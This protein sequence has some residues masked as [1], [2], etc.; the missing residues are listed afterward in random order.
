LVPTLLPRFTIAALVV[1][2]ALAST[3]RAATLPAHAEVRVGQC[4]A[5]SAFEQVVAAR[6]HVEF[7]R[8]VA[9]DIDR[10]GD[11]D[12]LATT[13]RSFTVWIN[14]GAGHLTAQRPAPGPSLEQRPWSNTFRGQGERPDPTVNADAPTFA[15]PTPRAHAPPVVASV[16]A[17]RL[18]GSARSFFLL[19]SSAP[20][21]PPLD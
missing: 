4:V 2:V 14:D 5:T 8:V 15:V 9:T 21:A 7:R 13:D 17:A 18:D 16:R 20:R 3:G 19:A 12:I 10:D 6:Y 1:L 11:I